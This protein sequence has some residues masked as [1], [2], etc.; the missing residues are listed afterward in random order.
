[1]NTNYS[2]SKNFKSNSQS[3]DTFS[4]SNVTLWKSKYAN[5]HGA[6]TSKQEKSVENAYIENL[7]KQVYFME[8]ELK[9]M[10][11]R[12]KEIEK[13]GGFSKPYTIYAIY[14]YYKYIKLNYSMMIEI[15]LSI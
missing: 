3:N 8:M 11:E 7:R 12:E 9:L 2:S 15:L 5:E 6:S 14:F 4:N 10:K 13:T 1:M